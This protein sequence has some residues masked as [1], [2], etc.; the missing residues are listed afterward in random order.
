MVNGHKTNVPSYLVKEG[1]TIKWREGSTKTEFYKI[2]VENIKAK[3]VASWLS[4][5]KQTMVGQVV[6]LPTPDEIGAKFNGKAVVEYY[7]R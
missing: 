2:L 5:D 1:D 7:S 4:L 6:S 3:S